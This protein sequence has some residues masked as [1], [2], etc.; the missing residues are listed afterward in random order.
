MI[1]TSVVILNWNGLPFLK[2]FLG[3]VMKY[4]LDQNTEVIIADNGSTDGSAE[5]LSANFKD[6]GFISTG[7]NLGFAG[8][9]NYALKQIDSEYYVL[10]NT[11]IQVT[12]GWLSPLVRFMDENP[13]VASCQPKIR[14][15]H[16][17]DHFEYAGAAGGFIDKYGFTFCRGRIFGHVEKDFGQYDDAADIFWSTGA[18]MIV[19][20][21]AWRECKGF[22]EDFFAHMEEV[23]LCWRFHNAGYRVCYLPQSFVYHV[24]GGSLPYESY[25]KTYLNFRNN[26]FLIYK[27]L[28]ERDLHKILPAR[29]NFNRLAA[30][31]FLLKGKTSN[32][33]AIF[34]AHADFSK[35]LDKL[36]E[37]RKLLR[38]NK[39]K[40]WG[41]LI[42][43]KSIVFEY[44]LKGN[45]TYRPWQ[46]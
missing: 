14:S 45:R 24:G 35:S 17:R 6:A 22:D 27:N 4:S 29:K 16:Q 46:P 39:E 32:V 10:L 11:D 36:R 2:K 1:K 40:D 26:L 21:K 7:Q 38:H 9:Y 15:Y 43:N 28:P 37:K 12:E 31:L 8:G 25:L 41:K 3:D 5:W 44:F 23:D 19:R 34:R 42:S 33:K 30:L 18:C 13:D 20:A